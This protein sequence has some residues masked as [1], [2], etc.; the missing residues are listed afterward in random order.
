MQRRVGGIRCSFGGSVEPCHGRCVPAGG[1]RLT[2]G[3]RPDKQHRWVTLHHVVELDVDE[4]A[5]I[6]L[7][8]LAAI[9]LSTTSGYRFGPPANTR[10]D[11]SVFPTWTTPIPSAGAWT[12]VEQVMRLPGIPKRSLYCWIVK[13]IVGALRPRP[14]GRVRLLSPT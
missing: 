1:G 3:A 8:R 5:D 9:S 4:A 6:G 10:F 14:R 11:Q 12:R 2:R 13:G 7:P